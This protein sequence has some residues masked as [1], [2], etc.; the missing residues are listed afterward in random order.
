MLV[1]FVCFKLYY[2]LP[3]IYTTLEENFGGFMVKSLDYT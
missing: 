2:D 1:A 3:S